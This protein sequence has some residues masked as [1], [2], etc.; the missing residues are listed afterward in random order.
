M[1]MDEVDGFAHSAECVSPTHTATPS[2]DQNKN[3]KEKKNARPEGERARTEFAEG[4][5]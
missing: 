1:T 3:K 4:C 5:R 2:T